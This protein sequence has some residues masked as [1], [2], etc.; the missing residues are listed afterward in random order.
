VAG[1]VLTLAAAAL[2]AGLVNRKRLRLAGFPIPGRRLGPGARSYRTAQRL[3]RGKGLPIHPATAPSETVAAAA[4]LG[5]E[6]A[7]VTSE[8]VGMYLAESF[9]DHLPT[10]TEREVLDRLLKDL[11]R[12]LASTRTDS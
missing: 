3:L 4:T 9:G 5:P 7:H 8:L 12:L 11:R 2:V 6:A 10:T 1:T